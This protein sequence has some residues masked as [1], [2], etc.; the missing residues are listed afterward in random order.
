MT[1]TGPAEVRR[2][3]RDAA[4]ALLGLLA[5]DLPT[6]TWTVN[7]ERDVPLEGLAMAFSSPDVDAATVD[8]WAAHFG[9]TPTWQPHTS[10]GYWK[11][12]AVVSGVRVEVWAGLPVQPA[13]TPRGDA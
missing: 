4:I 9:V 7:E 3:Q 2:R 11:A 10:G 13:S 5:L 12:R 8:A 6:V 1:R